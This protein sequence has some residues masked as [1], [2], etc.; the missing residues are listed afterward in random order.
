ATALATAL[1]GDAIATNLFLVG[2]AVQ[3]GLVPVSLAAL[4][5]AVELNGRGVAMNKRALAWG[6]L[7]AVD[8]AAVERA[9]R[10]GLRGAAPVAE[11]TLEELV[12]H[13]VAL[14]TAYQ[15]AAYAHRY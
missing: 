1:L 12:A 6:R 14:L 15:S 3:R 9:A 13:R 7:A 4:E 11:P 10:P 2:Y 5:R 8:L